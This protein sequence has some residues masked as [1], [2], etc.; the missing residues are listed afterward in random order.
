M[1]E[2]LERY[3]R[4]PGNRKTKGQTIFVHLKGQADEV[5]PDEEHPEC[6]DSSHSSIIKR[7]GHHTSKQNCGA[8][9]C[10]PSRSVSSN[11]SVDDHY[12]HHSE[13]NSRKR[14]DLNHS[15]PPG[16]PKTR[17]RHHQLEPATGANTK[18]VTHAH[19]HYHNHHYLHGNSTPPS[20]L[21]ELAH[22]RHYGSV[23]T[24]RIGYDLGDHVS[25]HSSHHVTHSSPHTGAGVNHALENW[26]HKN[27]QEEGSHQDHTKSHHVS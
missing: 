8:H 2:A 21:G 6:G 13:H 24:R 22:K 14:Q 12:C 19:V 17:D 4:E 5:D 18:S 7:H 3:L 1:N 25:K 16:S 15:T 10:S 11:S 23:G 26:W 27:V 20:C 9:H